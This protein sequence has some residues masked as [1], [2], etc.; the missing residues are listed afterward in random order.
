MKVIK[1]IVCLL[2]ILLLIGF[3]YAQD[4]SEIGPEGHSSNLCLEDSECSPICVNQ[5][6]CYVKSCTPRCVEIGQYNGGKGKCKGELEYYTKDFNEQEIIKVAEEF[7]VSRLGRQYFETHY[8]FSSSRAMANGRGLELF[9]TYET[10]FPPQEALIP[11]EIQMSIGHC[12]NK[13]Y[14]IIT[15]NGIVEPLKTEVTY[16]KALEIAKSE[17]FE[18]DLIITNGLMGIKMDEQF[19]SRSGLHFFVQRPAYI[20]TKRGDVGCDEFKTIYIDAFEGKYI[21]KVYDNECYLE[22][23]KKTSDLDTIIEPEVETKN[24][25]Q[26]LWEWLKNLFK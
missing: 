12:K 5:D 10:E 26:K 23:E 14:Y 13:D 1:N 17:G 4:D 16:D 3:T 2:M 15:G 18:K 9:F 24:I 7:L 22:S 11:L 21:E 19:Q 20:I 25:F 8:E 6:E